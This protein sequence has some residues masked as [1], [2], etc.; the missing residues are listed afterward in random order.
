MKAILSIEKN[1]ASYGEIES[2]IKESGIKI[3]EIIM[4]G[5]KSDIEIGQRW[6]KENSVPI[7]MFRPNRNEQMITG[8][9]VLIGI[10]KNSGGEMKDLL[11]RAAK[12]NLKIFIVRV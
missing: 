6:A 10:W 12:H 1:S 4:G 7:K 9:E 8:A 5:A 2:I 3:S 11:S